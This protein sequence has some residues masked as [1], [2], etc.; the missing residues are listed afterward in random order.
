MNDSQYFQNPFLFYPVVLLRIKAL[1]IL[2]NTLAL[3]TLT[4]KT[5]QQIPGLGASGQGYAGK[6]P[7]QGAGGGFLLGRK[8]HGWSDGK[9]GSSGPGPDLGQGA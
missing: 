6:L 1:W 3:T 8:V 4:R 9:D 2:Q 7:D 5:A